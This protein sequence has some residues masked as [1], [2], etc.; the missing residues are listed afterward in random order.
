MILCFNFKN[1]KKRGTAVGVNCWLM[2][3]DT[4]YL[5]CSD[6]WSGQVWSPFQWRER[7]SLKPDLKSPAETHLS[8]VQQSSLVIWIWQ[9]T[10]NKVNPTLRNGITHCMNTIFAGEINAPFFPLKNVIWKLSKSALS[11]WMKRFSSLYSLPRD[12]KIFECPFL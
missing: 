8:A 1:S 11:L 4:N 5:N 2:S 9:N 7:T 12:R 6:M 10:E 3:C